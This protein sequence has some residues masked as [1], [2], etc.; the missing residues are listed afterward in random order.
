MTNKQYRFWSND[1]ELN[2]F[3]DSKTAL[4]GGFSEYARK[5]FMLIMKNKLEPDTMIDLQKRKILVDI[6]Y[7]EI[8]TKIK[9]KELSFMSNFNSPVSNRAKEAIKSGEM[10]AVQ[11]IS[12]YDEKNYRFQCPECGILLT[13]SVFIFLTL[14]NYYI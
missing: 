9:E 11:T 12:F 7:K 2:Q 3:L 14:A 6:R 10:E 1:I 8:M 4:E 13:A 5:M